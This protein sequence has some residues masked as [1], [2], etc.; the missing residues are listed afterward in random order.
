MS[1]LSIDLEAI[2]LL[3]QRWQIRELGVIGSVLRADFRPDSD[4]DFV[5]TFRADAAWDLF[6]IVRLREEL[7]SIAGREIDL[8]EEP[9]VRNP[10]VLASIRRTKRVLYAA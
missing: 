5:V 9:A 6:D 8:I 3:C 1:A 4:V 10:Y 7:K 2:A